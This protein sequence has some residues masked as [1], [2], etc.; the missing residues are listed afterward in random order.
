MAAFTTL[1]HNFENF[2]LHVKYPSMQLIYVNFT[3]SHSPILITPFLPFSSLPSLGRSHTRCVFVCVCVFFAI[4]TLSQFQ[5]QSHKSYR[6]LCVL[7]FRWNYLLHGLDPYGYHLVNILF[8]IIVTLLYFRWVF[9]CLKFHSI[10]DD[11]PC[12]TN[13]FFFSLD[14]V[15][16]AW[17][18]GLEFLKMQ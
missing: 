16:N 3:L 10:N 14:I 13:T 9:C 4:R 11:I 2:R 17:L 6:P 18:I 5:E 12:N 8:H 7:T 1:H 15:E